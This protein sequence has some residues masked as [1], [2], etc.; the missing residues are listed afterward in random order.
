L[1][2]WALDH[3]PKVST[4]THD[5]VHN[6]TT[7]TITLCCFQE[8]V[9]CAVVVCRVDFLHGQRADLADRLHFYRETGSTLSVGLMLI[10]TTAPTLLV[11][12]IAG[13]FVDRFDR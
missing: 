9:F 13:V 12:L 10:A 8:P 11:G 1:A 4:G 2:S 7:R 6:F 3:S 5:W